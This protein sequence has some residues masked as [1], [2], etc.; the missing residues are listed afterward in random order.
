M[1]N[2]R[3]RGKR[4]ARGRFGRIRRRNGGAWKTGTPKVTATPTTAQEVPWNSIIVQRTV[5]VANNTTF[6]GNLLYIRDG[7]LAQI[8]LG[9]ATGTL[10]I[11]VMAADC[12]DLAGRPIEFRIHDYSTT[13]TAIVDAPVIGTA[14]S[15]PARN[16]WSRARLVFPKAISVEAKNVANA[17]TSSP[18]VFSGAVG[19]PMGVTNSTS[20]LILL[21]IRVL[22]RPIQTGGMGLAFPRILTP[23]KDVGKDGNLRVSA[24]E[25]GLSHSR[26]SHAM[27]I[28]KS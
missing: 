8:A 16:G 27:D 12:F 17:A 11:R 22:W 23:V 19:A 3:G 13:T 24:E 5:T 9:S 2:R 6:T 15:Y 25:L 7:L 1:V 20:T 18:L 10:S 4:Q 14:L 28:S 26:V 21:R